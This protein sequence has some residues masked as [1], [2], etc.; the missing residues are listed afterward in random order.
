[1]ELS[2]FIKKNNIKTFHYLKEIL[3]KDPY[4][5]K[6]DQSHPLFQ[7]N[8]TEKS[9]LKMPLVKECNGII[10][11]KNTLKIV[12][13]GIDNIENITTNCK[14]K[15]IIYIPNLRGDLIQIYFYNNIWK[16][17][18]KTGINEKEITTRFLQC[19]CPFHFDVLDKKKY[20]TFSLIDIYIYLIC[21]RDS[22]TLEE[23]PLL[24]N[25]TPFLEN[26]LI[27]I[28]ECKIIEP[29]AFDLFINKVNIDKNMI[30][31][32]ETMILK[33]YIFMDENMNKWKYDSPFYTKYKEMYGNNKSHF[34][35]YISLRKNVEK[36][37]EYLLLMPNEKK[38]FQ[39]Y[40]MNIISMAHFIL[41]MYKTRYLDNEEV[42]FPYYLKS[43]L[44]KVHGDFL[45]KR[46]KCN[47][48]KIMFELLEL[49]ESQF[50]FIY[51]SYEKKDNIQN[52]NKIEFNF[53]TKYV[54]LKIS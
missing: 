43:F 7:I 54:D 45:K 35:F 17:S 4:Y 16:I 33:G 37:Q 23:L 8:I 26:P 15:V 9:D 1:M 10:L 18:C 2:S 5:L 13:Y 36:M 42:Y 28:N 41:K 34:G 14:E 30:Y 48:N 21:I 49:K 22:S 3:V 19:A 50:L 40:E 29:Y 47:F 20:Y 46:I 6:I 32:N 12:F 44:Y 39:E 53:D 31:Y 27:H 25:T 51:K 24:L 52:E 11:E 38:K